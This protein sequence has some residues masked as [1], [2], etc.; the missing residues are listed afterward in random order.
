M[1]AKQEPSA[2]YS[3]NHAVPLSLT[4]LWTFLSPASVA[5]S[6]C[7]AWYF[8]PFLFFS[9]VKVEQCRPDTKS[10]NHAIC[11]QLVCGLHGYVFIIILA[12]IVFMMMPYVLLYR[13]THT[14]WTF[15]PI[16]TLDAFVCSVDG[17]LTLLALEISNIWSSSGLTGFLEWFTDLQ[18]YSCVGKCFICWK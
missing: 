6:S 1:K 14:K 2:D 15:Y 8:Q 5:L 11:L 13:I 4:S 17:H 3:D 10:K 18:A 16:H 12:I 7:P 9:R